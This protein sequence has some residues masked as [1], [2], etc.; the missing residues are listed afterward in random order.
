MIRWFTEWLQRLVQ[1]GIDL[2]MSLIG[3][4]IQ[5]PI[6][7]VARGRAPIAVRRGEA[8]EVIDVRHR[9]LR[10][11]HP[12]Q[13]A[14]FKG[15][16]APGTCHWV[17]LQHDRVVGVVTVIEAPMPDPPPEAEPRPT[18][19]LRGMA[20]LPELRGEGVGRE[21]LAAAQ[22]GARPLWCNA[23]V[24]VVPFYEGHGWRSTG[25]PFS[26]PPIGLHQRMW[27]P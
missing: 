11:G 4:L 24:G 15:D 20:V 2:A 26:I 13:D 6:E 19:Q 18:H 3:G 8:H 7:A 10:E 1:L 16:E 23:R 5:A 17:A 25:E 9:V 12:R 27:L 14:V 22:L 21:L